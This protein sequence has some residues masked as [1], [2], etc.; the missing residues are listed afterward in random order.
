VILHSARKRISGLY[1]GWHMMARFA[2]F[3]LPMHFLLAGSP[4]LSQA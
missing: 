2:T 4:I 3:N 1:S